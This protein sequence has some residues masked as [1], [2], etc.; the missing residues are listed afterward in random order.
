MLRPP[1][2]F[3]IKTFY[4]ALKSIESSSS[5]V[6]GVHIALSNHRIISLCQD[7]QKIDILL[8]G[9][10][11]RMESLGAPVTVGE[12]INGSFRKLFFIQETI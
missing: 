10:R 12:Q 2:N 4:F 9:S 5:F 7:L 3:F 11:S 6:R 1:Y 8:I